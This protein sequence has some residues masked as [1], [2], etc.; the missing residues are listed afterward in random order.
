VGHDPQHL[1]GF[2]TIAV[3]EELAVAQ[4]YSGVG[5]FGAE[6]IDLVGS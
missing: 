2:R 4:L 1:A 3:I 6:D 5:D